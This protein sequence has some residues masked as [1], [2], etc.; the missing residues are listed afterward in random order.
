[1]TSIHWI[2]STDGGLLLR[3][4]VGAS[5]FATLAVTDLKRNGTHAT[6]WRE[7]AFLLFC[8]AIAL[9]YGV[10]NDQIT[11]RISPEYFLYGKGLADVVDAHP[12]RLP[13]EA[14]KVGLKATWSVGLMVGVVILLANN[15]KPGWPQWR[16]R[17]LMRCMPWVITSAMGCAALLGIAGHTGA[18][19]LFS[20]DFRQMLL[21]NEYHP[22]CFMAAFGIHLGGYIGGL[23]G[24]IA[25][26]VYIRRSRRKVAPSVGLT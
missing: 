11:V 8:V 21:H 7:Y 16:Y 25:A 24:M 2:I 20:E 23:G 14:A 15:P 10:V 22:Y 26:V 1:M 9:L 12:E 3:V 18:L 13:W 4:C 6:R 5:I 19:A 17:R